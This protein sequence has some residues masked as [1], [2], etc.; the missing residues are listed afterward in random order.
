[1]LY[2]FMP[3]SVCSYTYPNVCEEY[4]IQIEFFVVFF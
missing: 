3:D 2:S 1:M 4:Y